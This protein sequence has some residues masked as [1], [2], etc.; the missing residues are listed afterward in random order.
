M[1][2]ESLSPLVTLLLIVPM[3]GAVAE[4][5]WIEV[6]KA[7]D[8]PQGEF[9]AE[10]VQ[11][12]AERYDPEDAFEA[13]VTTDHRQDGPAFGWVTDLKAEAGRL[14][15]KFR[16]V[17]EYFAQAINERMFKNRSV[18]LFRDGVVGKGHYLKAVSFLGAKAPQIKDLKPVG[19]ID[20]DMQELTAQSLS[21]Q[22]DD[23]GENEEGSDEEDEQGETEGEEPE[24]DGEESET[25]GE[26][27]ETQGE[28][29]ETEGEGGENEKDGDD[30]ETEEFASAFAELK[31]EVSRLQDQ[32]QE[33][34][35]EAE[36][37]RSER[38]EDEIETFME[39]RVPPAVRG[40]VAAIFDALQS[41]AVRFDHEEHDVENDPVQIFKSLLDRFSREEL[42]E[43]FADEEPSQPSNTDTSTLTEAVRQEM[44]ANGVA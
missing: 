1:L 44:A 22:F 4:T 42:F 24:T 33:A 41:D 30:D 16:D 38:Q 9:S 35:S 6:F 34:T 14:Y 39:E 5:D 31:Q 19:S 13:P 17:S 36:A 11:A 2:F 43:E 23:E 37:A 3:L 28:E 27:S 20:F 40:E 12:L 7:G 29:G 21:I 26:E 32:L 8:Y 10:D 18:E 15:A 25:E